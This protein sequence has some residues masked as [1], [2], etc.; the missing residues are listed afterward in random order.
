MTPQEFSTLETNLKTFFN[1]EVMVKCFAEIETERQQRQQ[2]ATN[3]EHVK[4]KNI[5]L[6]Y[7]NS[8]ELPNCIE[9]LDSQ[10]SLYFWAFAG[11]LFL[12]VYMYMRMQGKDL[13]QE[14][15][16]LVKGKGGF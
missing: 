3:I 14:V 9:D 1:D 2:C 10:G 12:L 4:S 6:E 11:V 13:V 7:A 16:Q 5:K 8:T 15:K